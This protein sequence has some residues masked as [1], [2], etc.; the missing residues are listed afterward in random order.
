MLHRVFRSYETQRT[1]NPPGIPA[2][3]PLPGGETNDTRR[4]GERFGED[5]V[6]A[7]LHNGNPV[8][9]VQAAQL[10]ALATFLR[11][12]PQLR[13]ETL[14][15]VTSLDRSHLPLNGDARF[16][17]GLSVSLLLPKPTPDRN[18]RLRRRPRRRRRDAAH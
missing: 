6:A 11:D 17:N 12:D 7:G 15:D 14:I 5:I 1:L 16:S 2:L 13:Y 8:V 3:A 10:K 4:I 18:R 9:Y